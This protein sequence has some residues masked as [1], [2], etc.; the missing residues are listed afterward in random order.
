MRIFL[1]E[2]VVIMRVADLAGALR[3][4]TDL[5]T[6][7]DLLVVIF[8]VVRFLAG[9]TLIIVVMCAVALGSLSLASERF[10]A[11]AKISQLLTTQLGFWIK[12]E[13]S[14][15]SCRKARAEGL[16]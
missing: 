14:H 2:G 13:A 3:G 1:G 5:R 6:R 12:S 9:V 8:E 7:A 4:A 16:S 10:L 15:A 11:G